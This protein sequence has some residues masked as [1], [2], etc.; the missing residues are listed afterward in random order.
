MR[1]DLLLALVQSAC[2]VRG[3]P[4]RID[5][6]GN[7]KAESSSS[8]ALPGQTS[9]LSGWGIQTIPPDVLTSPLPFSVPNIDTSM[10][11]SVEP[12]TEVVTDVPPSSSIALPSMPV[13]T[14]QAE[15][16]SVASE[17]A[18]L[19]LPTDENP[20]PPTENP[21]TDSPSAGNPPAESPATASAPSGGAA[22][23]FTASPGPDGLYNPEDLLKEAEAQLQWWIDF[24]NRI[25]GQ[26]Q[27]KQM[28]ELRKAEK[29]Q[30]DLAESQ[31][32]KNAAALQEMVDQLDAMKS[33]LPAPQQAQP[34]PAPPS[35]PPPAPA[36]PASENP[37]PEA[38]SPPPPSPDIGG[39]VPPDVGNSPDVG[40]GSGSDP[41]MSPDIGAGASPS[42]SDPML[43]SPVPLPFTLSTSTT[44]TT[45]SQETTGFA[46]KVPP[47]FTFPLSSS[48]PIESTPTTT[49][50]SPSLSATIFVG[51][52]LPALPEDTGM[53]AIPT[54]PASASI[55]TSA[56]STTQFKNSGYDS[57]DDGN[58]VS[59]N[60]G[61][62]EAPYS[63]EY[64]SIF[65]R[66][67][68][69]TA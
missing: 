17:S 48:L 40:G 7:N 45:K 13:D 30:Q 6:G 50:S 20:F 22:P 8:T 67:P 69:P 23:G 18:Q 26:G 34:T 11:M 61:L 39:S 63:V 16:P 54:E 38:E 66:R 24:Q 3:A 25:N 62:Y 41:G 35:P 53:P 68:L 32:Q 58:F 46:S 42:S 1:F 15:E 29:Q 55:N 28:E 2:L 9:D 27:Q 47:I 10:L 51:T 4:L 44:A 31:A 65:K 56:P 36:P 64:A 37:A 52:E 49:P 59:Q 14:A 43:V 60:G 21:P 57:F 12:I 5:M 19:P 33:Q